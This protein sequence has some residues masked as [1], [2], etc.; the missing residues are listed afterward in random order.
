MLSKVHF[1]REGVLLASF[2]GI[3]LPEVCPTEWNDYCKLHFNIRSNETYNDK[4]LKPCDPERATV[5]QQKNDK[6]FSDL[7]DKISNF[8]SI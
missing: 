2:M 3:D 7:T 5:V 1:F 8:Y 6:Y 4:P